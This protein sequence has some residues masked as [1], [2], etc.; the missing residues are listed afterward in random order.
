MSLRVLAPNWAVLLT[1]GCLCVAGC[2]PDADPSSQKSE[3]ENAAKKESA[4]VELTDEQKQVLDEIK[5]LAG[6]FSKNDRGQVEIIKLPATS[7]AS[8]KT[9]ALLT[10]FPHLERLYLTGPT[11][12][13]AGMDDV[14]KLT[15]LRVLGLQ[16]TKVDGEGIKKLAPLKKLVEINLRRTPVRDEAIDLLQQF[17]LLS[18]VN[19]TRTTIGDEAMKSLG[20]IPKLAVLILEQTNVTNEGFTYLQD[21]QPLRAVNLVNPQ[22]GDRALESLSRFKSMEAI[23]FDD[24]GL[25]SDA[26]F[27]YL[28]Q[29][30]NLEVIS[31]RRCFIGDAALVHIKDLPKLEKLYLRGTLVSAEGMKTISGMKSLKLLDLSEVPTIDGSAMEPVSKLTNLENLNLWATM[32]DDQSMKQVAKLGKLK[33]LNLLQT[34]ITNKGVAHLAEMPTLE[35]LNLGATQVDGGVI[36]ILTN[37]F[38]SLKHVTLSGSSVT[39][40]EMDKLREAR[41]E[42]KVD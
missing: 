35:R 23:W 8:D 13:N 27:K 21:D 17:P 24:C 3:S 40:E 39:H 6:D 37:G 7:T 10:V 31:A 12:T 19:L 5:S 4:P 16:A 11:F 20:K 36:E 33:S 15:S 42:L 14:A 41:P 25:V 26:G 34:Q 30:P 9:L 1:V 18:S 22:L 29:L 28:G 2:R 38:P 32:V